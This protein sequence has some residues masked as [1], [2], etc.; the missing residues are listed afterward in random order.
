MKL[1]RSVNKQIEQLKGELKNKN[2]VIEMY[3]LMIQKGN[4][5]EALAYS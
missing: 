3:E 2:K 1:Q 4:D 5:E